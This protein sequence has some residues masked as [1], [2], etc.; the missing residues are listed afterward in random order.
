MGKL[1]FL[2]ICW[3]YVNFMSGLTKVLLDVAKHPK[4]Y[5]NPVILRIHGQY[6]D[7]RYL[8]PDILLND[9]I[10]KLDPMSTSF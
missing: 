5:S 4:R 10:P 1:Q 7:A 9:V 6:V 8:S 3:Q 2:T